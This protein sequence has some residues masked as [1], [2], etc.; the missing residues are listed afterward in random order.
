MFPRQRRRVS[1][2]SLLA[3]LFAPICALA[4]EEALSPGAAGGSNTTA[5]ARLEHAREVNLEYSSNLPNFM[6]DETAKRYRTDGTSSEWRY[7]DTI[8]TEIAIQGNRAVRERIRRNGKAWDQPFQALPGFKWYGG[9]GTEIRP[10][11][12]PQCPTA[13]EYAG[14][15]VERGQQLFEFR[16]SS[17]PDGCFAFFYDEHS[18]HNPARSGHV[19]IADGGNVIRLDETASGFP[20]DFELAQRVERVSWDS[21]KIGDASHLLPVAASFLVTYSSGAR[22]RVD[23]EFR[24]HRHFEAKTNLKFQQ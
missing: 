16:F 21:V 3:L 2:L 8:E 19:F 18:R 6:A 20:T 11:F 17:P 9:F 14:Q 22:W 13:V 24:N 23:V 12:D 4:Q 15:S 10:V 1:L 7:F 5:R